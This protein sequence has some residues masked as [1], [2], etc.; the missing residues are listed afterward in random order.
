MKSARP[1]LGAPLETRQAL[2]QAGG[3][4]VSQARKLLNFC[5]TLLRQFHQDRC[6]GVAASLSYTTLLSLVPLLA[7]M[8]SVLAAFPVFD[9]V[10]EKLQDFIFRNFVPAS[11]EM[12]QSYFEGF[13][14][15][16]RRLTGP[17]IFFLVVVALMLMHSIDEAINDIWRVRTQRSWP[18]K[19]VVYWA[20]L[21]LGPLLLAVSI[22][23]TS[24]LVSLPVVSN[25]NGAIE[26]VRSWTWSLMPFLS[27]LVALAL[28]YVLVPNRRIR[29]RHGLGGAVVAA[30]LFELAKHG[31]TLYV[32]NVQTYATIYGALAVI[33]LFLVWIY[34][35]WAVV[36]LGAELSY[37]L[38]LYQ[39]RARPGDAHVPLAPLVA[40]YRIV[41]HL[42]RSQQRGETLSEERLMRLEPD[43]GR[44]GLVP[45]MEALEREKYVLMVS[46]GEWVLLRDT[47]EITLADLYNA[48]QHTIAGMPGLPGR[49]DPWNRELLEILHDAEEALN[50]RLRIPLKQLYQSSETKL[51]A[52]T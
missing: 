12:I 10:V 50:D 4:A 38:T 7:V 32:S 33:P 6:L 24:F 19:F 48:M 44:E 52:P 36:L 49:Q 14:E 22:A 15:Q 5:L 26:G 43:L 40:A 29:L 16:A 1:L 30:L 21:T 31:F 17:G 47:G 42:W 23:V 2:A 28:L 9:T 18:A 25:I 46:E 35:S 45:V 11:G 8:F 39:E 3:N 34:V 51:K 20:V 13:T 37:C 27:T 41:G